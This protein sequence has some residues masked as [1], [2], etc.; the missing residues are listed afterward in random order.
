M[1][2]W[3]RQL[4]LGRCDPSVAGGLGH[5]VK[6]L[7]VG[8]FTGSAYTGHGHRRVARPEAL[9]TLPAVDVVLGARSAGLVVTQS[10]C[11]WVSWMRAHAQSSL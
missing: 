10:Q 7:W 9:G 1:N 4:H 5:F 8:G 11:S 6:Q 2:G 3:E